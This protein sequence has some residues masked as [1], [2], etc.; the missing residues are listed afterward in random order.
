MVSDAPERILQVLEANNAAERDNTRL[1]F[2][3]TRRRDWMALSCILSL[4]AASCLFAWLNKPWL[5]GTALFF[6][7]SVVVSGFVKKPQK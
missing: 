3:E 7:V 5:S 6:V 1:P 4:V 2:L